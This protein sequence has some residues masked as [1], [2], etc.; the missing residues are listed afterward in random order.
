MP[1]ST[2][3]RNLLFG[4]LALQMDFIS[5]EQLVAGMNAWVLAKEKPLGQI[6]GEQKALSADRRTLLDALVAEH[7]KQH[8]DDPQQSLAAISSIGEIKDDL[9]RINDPDLT[10][11]VMQIP[12][13][14]AADPHMTMAPSVGASTSTGT[15]FRIVRSYARGGLGEVFVAQD[16]ELHRE[17]AVK[18]IQ[19]RHADEVE[20]RVRFVQ[21]AEITGGLEH[22]GIVPVYGL[23]TYSDGRPYYAMRFIRGD[24]LKDAIEDFH[25]AAGKKR[26]AVDRNLELRGLL[27]RFIDVCEAIDYAHSRGVLHRDLKPGNI[28]LGKYG[29]TLV[30]DWGLAKSLDRPDLATTMGESKLRPSTASGSAAT[31]M[32]SAVGTP[33]FMSPEQ[34]GGRLDLLGPTSDVYS[35]GATLYCL[36]T[37]KTAFQDSDLGLVLRKVERAEFP[38]PREVS[39]DVPPPLEAICLKAMALYQADRYQTPR[40]LADDIEHWLADEPVTAYREPAG[41]RLARWTRRNRAWAQSIAAAV[42]AVAVVAVVAAVLI[43]R[44]WREEAAARQEA[45]R[46][47]R[48]AR[49]AVNDYFTLVSEN[50]LLDVPGLQPLRKELLESALRYYQQFLKERA[51][52]PSLHADVALTWYR[53][54]RIE[55]EI[56]RN[57]DAVAALDKAQAIQ[58]EIHKQSPSAEE[59][60]ELADTDNALGDLAQRTAKLDDAQR[61]FQHAADLRKSLVDANPRDAQLERK[62]ANSHENLAVVDGKLGKLDAAKQEFAAADNE[63]QQLV[64][65]HPDSTQ[66]RRDLAQGRYNLATVFREFH[67]LPAAS[68]W[69]QH[70]ATD[71]EDLAKREPRS[72]DI[73]REWALA[74]RVS[75]DIQA[76][77]GN[78]VAA[79]ADY[80][81]ARQIAEPLA[82][83]NPLL[84]PLQDD[85]A[86]IYMKIGNLKLRES[87]SAEALEQLQRAHG[88]LEQ[89]AID[90]PT[91][92]RYR[93]DLASCLRTIGEIQRTTSRLAEAEG[94]WDAARSVQ[95]QLVKESPENA[96][97]ELTLGKLM[98][99]LA[100]VR[101]M[102]GKKPDALATSEQATEHLR[103]AFDQVPNAAGFRAALSKGYANLAGFKRQSGKP[104]EA[105]AI[106]EEQ[107]KLWPG[108]ADELFKVARELALA[109]E[110]TGEATAEST[111][112]SQSTDRRAIAQQAIEVLQE[113][114]AAGFNKLD[115]LKSDP[116]F[117][118]LAGDPAFMQ[119]LEKRP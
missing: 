59:T 21:E 6:L 76:M 17:V 49:G 117:K 61:W 43:A 14:V 41:E 70:A 28:M 113:A 27:R 84:L 119:L 107:R 71:F 16:Q 4:I 1:K 38:R 66:Y 2:D 86:N 118:V 65:A 80:E 53:V 94:T 68:D 23:G 83:G 111:T 56:D 60:A 114:V 93:V 44:S 30:V 12:T 57:A 9:Q 20:S 10:V 39:K 96:N 25:S 98:D 109:A 104:A 54:G 82:R 46:G 58:E 105:A 79:S 85:V 63:R 77:S 47:F 73:H 7:L 99:D 78:I 116:Q 100:V 90:D 115:E 89:L 92:S 91:V 33:Q 8:G 55:A 106:A 26:S 87:K 35:L 37:G 15:R 67:E 75:G 112:S 5:R 74:V 3:D 36:L 31:L 48:E 101:W 52:D 64:A 50:K 103:R 108:N 81:H 42:F 40:A 11:S 18:Q 45:E 34:A 24:S 110:A 13:A 88:I 19:L 72:I 69:I 62:L 102:L 29:E 51:D 97:Y 95:E 22:P 32:G